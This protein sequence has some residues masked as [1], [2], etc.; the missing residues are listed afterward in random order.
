MRTKILISCLFMA[1]SSAVVSAQAEPGA[2]ERTQAGSKEAWGGIKQGSKEAWG[3]VKEGSKEA[4]Q[5]TRQ[6]SK[7]AW[8][9]LKGA[10]G[11]D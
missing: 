3:E 9:K 6:G 2:W 11:D 7:S 5:A 1:L 10:F 8:Q 4:W